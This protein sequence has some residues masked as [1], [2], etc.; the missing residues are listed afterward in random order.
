MTFSQ[1][2]PQMM[3]DNKLEQLVSEQLCHTTN[4]LCSATQLSKFHVMWRLHCTL[5]VLKKL[6]SLKMHRL[7]G[8]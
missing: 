2:I 1:V 7:I 5:G 4:L 6:T 3:L 8:K